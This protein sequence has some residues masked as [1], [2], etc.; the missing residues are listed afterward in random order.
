MSKVFNYDTDL[1]NVGALYDR[2]RLPMSANIMA[3]LLRI[4]CDMP[5]EVLFGACC[6]VVGL[7]FLSLHNIRMPQNKK[8]TSDICGDGTHAAFVGSITKEVRIYSDCGQKDNWC[9]YRLRN[10]NSAQKISNKMFTCDF[11]G[12]L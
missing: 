10:I 4:H 6:N 12:N 2:H 9:C 5:L 7:L 11:I 3:G 8:Q 1:A